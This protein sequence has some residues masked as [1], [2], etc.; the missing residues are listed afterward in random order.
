MD[1]FFDFK[2]QTLKAN[3]ENEVENLI[4]NQK[5]SKPINTTKLKCLT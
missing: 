2:S 4:K 5:N 1:E 3:Q